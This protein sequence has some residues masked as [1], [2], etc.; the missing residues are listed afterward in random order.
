M[1]EAAACALDGG[2]AGKWL[3]VGLLGAAED[4]LLAVDQAPA[5]AVRDVRLAFMPADSDM[6]AAA[7]SIVKAAC[8][9]A[10]G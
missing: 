7:D 2:V 3:A 8:R 6:A 5:L 10:V 9:L 1:L 4:E